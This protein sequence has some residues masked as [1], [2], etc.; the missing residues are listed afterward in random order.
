MRDARA[1]QKLGEIVRELASVW[2]LQPGSGDERHESFSGDQGDEIALHATV[3]ATIPKV[4]AGRVDW[5][6]AEEC[7]RV[8]SSCAAHS[9]RLCS[10]GNH[11]AL[12]DILDAC[13]CSAALPSGCNSLA[14]ETLLSMFV[15]SE[16]RVDLLA[17]L[18]SCGITSLPLR[19]KI[20]NSISRVKRE[21]GADVGAG[22]GAEAG[23]R[24]G[25]GAKAYVNEADARPVEPWSPR[26][27]SEVV[28]VRCL[29][30]N[31]GGALLLCADGQGFVLGSA[32]L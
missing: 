30:A 16:A 24:V 27:H 12:R 13:G 20:A 5:M 9:S 23:A 18:K 14:C 17:F 6:D 8:F 28:A 31:A 19:Q 1:G 2:A 21:V 10:A 32:E 15:R 7:S 29:Q 4:G 22:S 25:V 26:L 3:Q 11:S